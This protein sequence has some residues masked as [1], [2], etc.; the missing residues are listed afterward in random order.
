MNWL[1]AILLIA[2]IATSLIGLAEYLLLRGPDW[3]RDDDGN[4]KDDEP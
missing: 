1:V 2:L 4:F 3:T